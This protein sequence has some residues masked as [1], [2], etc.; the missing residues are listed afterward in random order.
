[1]KEAKD[2]TERPDADAAPS[3]AKRTLE[4][5]HVEALDRAPKD[6]ARTGNALTRKQQRAQRLEFEARRSRDG[7]GDGNLLWRLWPFLRPER[8]LLT[9]AVVCSLLTSGLSLCRPLIMLWAI[10]RSVA[11][12][13]EKLILLGGLAF[14]AAAIIEQ[15][16]GFVQ[17]YATQI[18]GA[19]AMAD[20]RLH[21]FRFIGRLPQAFFD[22]QPVGRLVTRVTNDVDSIQELFNSGIVSVLGSVLRLL[23]VVV[24]MLMLDVKLSLVAFAALPLIALVVWWV[25]RR[26]RD[27]FRAIRGETARMNS[28]MN[29]QVTGLAVVQA[30]GQ[31]RAMFGQFEE[32]NAAYRDANVS[33]IKYEAIQDAA[34]D[35]IGAIAMAM[36]IV[37]LGYH[38]A[39]FGTVVALSAYLGLFFEPITA[40]AQLYT[41]VQNALSGAERVFG[42]LAEPAR[43]MAPMTTPDVATGSAQPALAQ[44]DP[45]LAIEFRNVTFGYKAELPVLHDVSFAAKPGQVIAL[46]GP[47]GS[48]KTTVTALLLRLYEAWSG[49]I[50]VHGDDVLGLSASELRGRFSVVPQ[51]VLLFPGTLAENVALGSVP[52]L[53]RVRSVLVQMGVL[54]LFEK[55]EDGLLARVHVSGSNFSAGERQLIAFARALY[56][57][58]DILI[59]DEATASVDSDT[60]SR[61]QKALAVLMTGRTSIVV[62]HRLSTIRAAHVIIVLSRGQ[63][64]ES[65]THEQLIV[66]GGLYA[67]LYDLQISRAS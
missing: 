14:A 49:K 37:A 7:L 27:A 51:E 44:G 56:R 15:V 46:V 43:D 53:E 39:S 36:I 11:T 62:A 57:N 17:T 31:E 3:T 34:V 54:D 66:A 5:Y 48:G 45:S 21:V 16:L 13:D 26:A 63:I 22:H 52:D 38:H 55:R 28:N 24:L 9:V 61:M 40:L 23:G 8:A 20:L 33:A 60:E 67:A 59:L 19:R 4:A 65:G 41:L 12:K 1:V 2:G 58:A 25:R 10:D 32:I 29:E 64:V 30:F 18:V 35:A 50:F 42:L 6:V 47:T